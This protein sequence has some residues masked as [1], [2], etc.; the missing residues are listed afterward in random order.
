M[1]MPGGEGGAMPM[2]GGASMGM[3]NIN[4][5]MDTGMGKMEMAPP[6]N[7]QMIMPPPP[8]GMD[9]MPMMPMPEPGPMAT[10]AGGPAGEAPA[11]VAGDIG[12]ERNESFIKQPEILA[13]VPATAFINLS[14]EE[15]AS[16]NAVLQDNDAG[17]ALNVPSSTPNPDGSFNPN[18]PPGVFIIT[19]PALAGGGGFIRPP[20]G[21]TG[22]L[23]QPDGQT[24]F[25]PP[26]DG[27]TGFLP[28]PDGQTGFLPPP[29]G[30]TGFLPP[31]SVEET[32]ENGETVNEDCAPLDSACEIA[33]APSPNGPIREEPVETVFVEPG[34]VSRP[35]SETRT[36]GLVMLM[37]YSNSSNDIIPVS[38]SPGLTYLVNNPDVMIH[39][40]KAVRARGSAQGKD[41]QRAM[42]QVAIDH[43]NNFGRIEGRQ[44][45]G[46]TSTRLLVVQP[47]LNDPLI[48]V[49]DS[50]ALTYLV[51][52][53]DVLVHARR[54]VGNSGIIPGRDFQRAMERV[55][56]EHYNN[57]GRT[58]GRASPGR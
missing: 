40:Q 19:D 1:P 5:M 20:D 16:V 36:E 44:L 51:N 48:K 54:V 50:A 32:P 39:A 57:F 3:P 18:P 26:P 35:D 17:I 43:Y 42:E 45:D 41:F 11:G 14:P 27:Q 23:P 28:P 33:A 10:T 6:I 53:P 34:P 56:I 13:G 58:E 24:G 49:S 55:A 7:I 4:A 31:P 38:Q 22:F 46:E 47:R 25:L 52:N 8:S 30:Q 37:T 9:G 21:Q 29:D 2:P 12:N 15:V